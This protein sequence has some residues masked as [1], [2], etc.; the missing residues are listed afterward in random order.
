MVTEDKKLLENLFVL[1]LANNHWG[2]LDRGLDIVSQFSKVVR[3]NNV[4][5][6]IKLQFRDV[7]SFIHPDHKEHDSR[8]IQ[9]TLAT[10]LT[11]KEF[12]TLIDAIVDSGCLPMATPFDE[13]S[14]EFCGELE[15]PVIKIASS[16][17]ADWPLM[18][19]VAKLDK[20]VM[21]SN[22]GASEK[23]TDDVV[24]F[25]SN[26]NIELGIN[27]CVSLYPSE[28][29]ELELN[30]I[31]YL[32]NRYPNHVIGLSTHEYHDWFSSMLISYGKGARSWER[33]IDIEYP[34]GDSR[35]VSKYCSLPKQIDEWFKAFKKAEEM[36]GSSNKDTKRIITDKEIQYLDELVRGVY[37]KKDIKKG[38]KFSNDS[39]ERDFFMSV[40]LQKGQLSCREILNGEELTKD[41][42]V[43]EPLM[44]DD[45]DHPYEDNSDFVKNIKKRGL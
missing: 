42:K 32:K 11:K 21:I 30:Q 37:A 44:I 9:K 24:K 16:D 35:S 3:Y 7:D 38:Y 33:H 28:D 22:G 1:E 25:F 17:I 20:P 15:L 34:E 10:K 29:S 4:K 12:K 26:R 23:D 5:A 18:E 39:F 31:D 27:H 6:A 8:Y 2:N 45:I 43:N 40:P 14:V 19:S 13:R 36:C 41:I